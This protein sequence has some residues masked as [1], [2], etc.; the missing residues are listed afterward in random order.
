MTDTELIERQAEIIK[1]QEDIICELR[2]E[3]SQLK[4]LSTGGQNEL[5][6]E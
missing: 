6:A 2:N 5:L 4:S 3:N 1:E